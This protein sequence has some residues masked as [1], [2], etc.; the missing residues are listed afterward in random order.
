MVTTPS[1]TVTVKVL[2]V[3][4]SVGAGVG[5]GVGSAVL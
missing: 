4:A 5:F 3:G 1:S 2:L